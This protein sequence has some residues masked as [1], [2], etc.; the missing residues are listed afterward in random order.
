LQD[1]HDFLKFVLDKLDEEMRSELPLSALPP[2]PPSPRT[3]THGATAAA[4]SDARKVM[5]DS[6]IGD[7]F[8]GKLTTTVECDH[9]GNTS[10]R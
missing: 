8:R 3:N 6:I 7:A 1:V 9:C 10:I 4:P 2:P 5:L